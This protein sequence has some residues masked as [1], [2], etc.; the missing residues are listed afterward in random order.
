MKSAKFFEYSND[1]V[2]I[3]HCCKLTRRWN[4]M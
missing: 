4:T 2:D 1:I 3:G